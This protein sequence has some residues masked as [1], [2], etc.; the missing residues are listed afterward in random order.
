MP[1]S[2]SKPGNSDARRITPAVER[3][4][5]W[6]RQHRGA[7]GVTPDRSPNSGRDSAGPGSVAGEED[8][9]AGLEDA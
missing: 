1:L 8:P 6:H 9:G 3:V 7:G 5:E 2:E 4:I